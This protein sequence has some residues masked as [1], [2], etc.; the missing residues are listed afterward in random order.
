MFCKE[1]D[2]K[3]N[4]LKEKFFKYKAVKK[5]DNH[6]GTFKPLRANRNKKAL[7][8]LYKFSILLIYFI[9]IIKIKVTTSLRNKKLNKLNE[10]KIK[11]IG[12]G[13]QSILNSKFETQPSEILVNG[14][15]TNID[16]QNKISNLDNDINIITMKWDYNVINCIS[17]FAGL[18]NLTE[19]D[20]SNFD[21]SKIKSMSF[22]FY[23]CSNLESVNF[24]N[25]KTP[26][27]TNIGLLFYGCESLLSVDLSSLNTSSVT[28]MASMFYG[29]TSLTSINLTNLNTSKLTE[30]GY[31]FYSCTS[32]TSVDLSYFN[33]SAVTQMNY[34]FSN[35]LSLTS[36]DLSKF[37]TDSL[38]NVNGLFSNCKNLTYINMPNF[39]LSKVTSLYSLFK[40]CQNLEYINVNNCK[41]GNQITNID[42][43]FDEVPNNIHIALII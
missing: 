15:S 24:S 11:I 6:P 25:I 37:N 21:G 19:V 22:M 41:E 5:N 20:L 36:I 8:E 30:M 2:N 10:I 32:L 43:F 17:M 7:I 1:N 3:Q 4:Y 27:L 12:S 14:N 38:A 13:E 29:C 16:L 40:G 39:D 9:I 42:R 35:C 18:T 31:L 26:Y 34:M 33:T 28:N 23:D